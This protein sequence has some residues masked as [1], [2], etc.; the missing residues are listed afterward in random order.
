MAELLEASL[1]PPQIQRRSQLTIL[2]D[3]TDQNVAH[4]HQT[5]HMEDVFSYTGQPDGIPRAKSYIF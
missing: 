1:Y 2:A 4:D 5:D 3:V